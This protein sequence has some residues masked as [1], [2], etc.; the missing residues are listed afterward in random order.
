MYVTKPYEFIRFGVMDVTKP[1][2]FIGFGA[3]DVTKPYEFIRFGAMD[4]TKPYE[5]IGFGT[6][7]VTKPYKFVRV[8]AGVEPEV[9]PKPFEFIG[10]GAMDGPKPYKFIRGWLLGGILYLKFAFCPGHPE[11]GQP[12]PHPGFENQRFL[13]AV[14]RFLGGPG[15]PFLADLGD[16]GGP[17]GILK[18]YF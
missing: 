8:G 2:E 11:G 7:D 13:G 15:P 3:M 6:M 10:F 1:Y 5:F 16:S 17:A 18:I 14:R 4:A 9:C 12:V